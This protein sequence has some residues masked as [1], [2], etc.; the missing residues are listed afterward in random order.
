MIDELTGL[1]NRRGFLTL[2]EHQL[3]IVAQ[4]KGMLLLLFVDMDNLY[5]FNKSTKLPLKRR[6]DIEAGLYIIEY[7]KDRQGTLPILHLQ[8]KIY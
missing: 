7:G 1:Y 5:D 4:T 2:A 8:G 6:I 3:Q